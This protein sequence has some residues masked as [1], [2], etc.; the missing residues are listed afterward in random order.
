MGLNFYA[1]QSK[2]IYLLDKIS[3]LNWRYEAGHK[4]KYFFSRNKG[5]IP[6]DKR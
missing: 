5:Q 3:D 6:K 4:S 1:I 2:I